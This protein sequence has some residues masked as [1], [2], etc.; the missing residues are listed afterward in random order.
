MGADG[1]IVVFGRLEDTAVAKAWDGHVV[2][3]TPSWNLD[4]NDAFVAETIAQRRPVYLASPVEGNMIQTVGSYAGQPSIYVVKCWNSSS[5][6]GNHVG[7]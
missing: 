1:D 3:D 4:V 5:M 6:L 7:R 2:L